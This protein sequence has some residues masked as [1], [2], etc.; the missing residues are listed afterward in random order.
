MTSDTMMANRTRVLLALL[1]VI[2][3]AV[4]SSADAEN[5]LLIHAD[6]GTETISKNIYGHFA[7]HLGRCI[8]EGIW[9]GPE[10]AIPNLR[11]IRKDVVAAL[12]QIKAPVIRWPGG[13]FA[14]SYHWKDGVGPYE[15]RRAI[16]NFYWGKV[17]ENNHFG[18]HE[19]LDFCE[20]VG[21]DPY[22][23]GNVG[24]GTVREMAEWIE[25]I[26][27]GPETTMGQWRQ[28]NGRQQPWKLPFLAVGNESWGCGGNMTPA[29]YKDL[30]KQ[31]ATFVRS[32][33]G[34]SLYK[35]ASGGLDFR[36]EWTEVLMR[37]ALGQLSGISY[38]Y[39]TITEGWSRKTSATQFNQRDWFLTMKNA[40]RLDEHMRKNSEIMDKYDPDQRVGLVV[41]E[42][43][44]WYDVE[45][46]TNPSFL[47]QQNTLRDA[48]S[49]GM[50][51]NIF[52]QH[53]GRVSMANIAQTV[54]VLQAMILTDKEKM[55]VTPTYHVFDLY[56]VHHEATLLPSELTGREYQHEEESIP[57]LSASASRDQFGK[58]HI[59]ICNLDLEK[60]ARI[61]CEIQGAAAKGKLSGQILTAAAM[62]A[63]NTFDQPEQ[64]KPGPFDQMEQ[65]GNILSVTIPAKSVIVLEVEE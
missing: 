3:L 56:K 23:C 18:T 12:K 54:N 22:I 34:N 33:P 58:I 30:Y 39:Y 60:A 28:Q 49:A 40:Y 11:G 46:G 48:L 2:A 35:V 26:T 25:Y 32:Y 52:N 4:R 45:P 10:S 20:Q 15:N 38:H 65:Q 5:R 55:I 19:F 62:N 8:Y 59:S 53:C 24:S 57:A 13:C 44:T 14:D 51:L 61:Q 7:E 6:K 47:Y 29:Y 43:G 42:W 1:G 50:Q 37:E 16:F 31:Y 17:V 9:V 27:G 21:A 41:D 64:V 36:Y 63:H